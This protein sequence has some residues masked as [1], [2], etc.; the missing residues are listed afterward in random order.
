MKT[1]EDGHVPGVF[2]AR[3]FEVRIE[4]R[5]DNGAPHG[6]PSSRADWEEN[7]ALQAYDVDL[8]VMIEG[9]IMLLECIAESYADEEYS[10]LCDGED[11]QHEVSEHVVDIREKEKRAGD[12]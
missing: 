10:Y 5:S 2:Q 4:F 8:L 7:Q 11:S 3:I 1:E 9:W 6:V 12:E